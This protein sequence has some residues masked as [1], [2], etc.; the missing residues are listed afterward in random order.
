M[1][2]RPKVEATAPSRSEESS[3]A[4]AGGE[5][6]QSP[7]RWPTQPTLTEA[8]ARRQW[9]VGRG[10]AHTKAGWGQGQGTASLLADAPQSGRPAEEG[11]G[12]GINSP[13]GRSGPLPSEAVASNQWAQPLGARARGTGSFSPI[14]RSGRPTIEAMGPPSV[15]TMGRGRCPP[16]FA[17]Q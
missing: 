15:G 13:V 5:R 9:A 16:W 3:V 8:V 11:A 12:R 10:T 6:G 2:Q 7:L 14:G 1:A 4:G 17:W